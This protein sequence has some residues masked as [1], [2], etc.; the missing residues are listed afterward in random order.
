MSR[1]LLL[2]SGLMTALILPLHAAEPED[3]NVAA[4][5]KLREALRNTMTQLRTAQ[6]DLATA[7]SAQAAAEAQVKDLTLKAEATAKQVTADQ[8][9][10]RKK[11]EAAV[12]TNEQLETMLKA[13]KAKLEEYGVKFPQLI[14]LAKATEAERAKL[15]DENSVLK[16][17]VR[18][19]KAQ[20]LELFRLANEILT[21]Y[22]KFGVGD[23][24]KAREPF[25]GI[26][27]A[28]LE[29]QVQDYRDKAEDLR[30]PAEK[31]KKPAPAPSTH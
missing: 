1:S 7:Q 20:N 18:D 4:N 6:T 29:T 24:L 11:L 8:L 12:V 2:L 31:A 17:R 16:A 25:T 9:E 21:R 10:A 5:A 13:A 26:T 22:E 30:I 19:H 28:R 3:P 27:R 14:D 15:A 23:A